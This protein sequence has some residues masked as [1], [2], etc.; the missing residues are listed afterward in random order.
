MP[1]PPLPSPEW[2]LQQIAAASPA[3]TDLPVADPRWCDFTASGLRSQH[4]PVDATN[5]QRVRDLRQVP[6]GGA[7]PPAGDGSAQGAADGDSDHPPDEWTTQTSGS[8]ATAEQV[9]FGVDE[10]LRWL[11]LKEAAE[12]YERLVEATG[13][14]DLA[15]L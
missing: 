5:L 4:Y 6:P 1:L 9:R 13:G 7:P 2:T 11:T 10:P 12:L 3:S 8:L 15:L 14:A